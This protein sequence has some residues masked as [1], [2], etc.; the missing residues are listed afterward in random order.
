M[1]AMLIACRKHTPKALLRATQPPRRIARPIRH[2]VRP[3]AYSRHFEAAKVH[4]AFVLEATTR[5]ACSTVHLLV[6]NT[7]A[8]NRRTAATLRR[9]R[10]P[11]AERARQHGRRYGHR[12]GWRRRDQP[13]CLQRLRQERVRKLR[14]SICKKALFRM[15]NEPQELG[16]VLVTINLIWLICFTAGVWVTAHGFA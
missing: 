4:S 7:T 11:I 5:T 2:H 8:A 16:A 3:T 13:L 12:H 9:L 6:P 10:H 1:H 15:R 14:S